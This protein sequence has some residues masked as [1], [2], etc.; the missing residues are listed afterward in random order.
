[1]DKNIEKFLQH[2]EVEKNYSEHTILNYRLDLEDFFAFLKHDR[3]AEVEYPTLRRFLAE[4][5][6]REL[7]PRSV[8]RKL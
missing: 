3:V 2:M 5:R 1:M 4:L 8:S 6:A 7:R